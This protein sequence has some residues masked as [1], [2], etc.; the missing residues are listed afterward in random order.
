MKKLNSGNVAEEQYATTANKHLIDVTPNTRLLESLRDMG[1]DNYQAIADVID[2]SVDAVIAGSAK[3]PTV[4]ILTKFGGDGK[5]YITIVDNGIGMTEETLK[6]ALKLGS[7]TN[8]V[9]DGE[10]GYFGVGLN[11]AA[12]S[13]GRGFRVITKHADGEYLC[14]GF[15]LDSAITEK[16]WTFASI[17]KASTTDKK[18]FNELT[19]NSPTGTIIEIYK[20]DRISNRHKTHFDGVLLKNLGKIYRFYIS[21]KDGV[22]KVSFILNG[23]KIDAIDPM[24]RDLKGTVLLNKEVVNQKYQFNVDGQLAEIVVRYFYVDSSLETI[25]PT[26]KLGGRSN[27]FYI[28]RN[29]RQ[30]MAE[31]RLDFVGIDKQSSWLANFRAEILFDGKYDEIFKTNV[32]KSRIILPQSLTD[33][34]QKDVSEAVKFCK[35]EKKKTMPEESEIVD[36]DVQKDVK[37]II[38]QKNDT[39]TTPT[40]VTDKNGNPIKKEVIEGTEDEPESDD[41][42]KR[43]RKKEE[44]PRNEKTFNKMNVDFVNFGEDASFFSS[45]HQGNG[46]FLIRINLDH[47]FYKEFA[48]LDRQGKKFVIDLLHSFSLA[49]RQ[50]IYTDDLTQI[51]ELIRTWSNFLRRD[52]TTKE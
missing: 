25:Y 1:Y 38:K 30:I 26:E 21:G 27:G 39:K 10:L 4:K 37:S 16:S 44:K 19:N 6:E 18:Y 20:L 34:M 41:K 15:D 51:D 8:K 12:I 33:L 9:R 17:E 52:L 31:E 43:N 14:G 23:I 11:A 13:I 35:S 7:N 3:N 2:N 24:G 48:R 29:H 46:K 28:M 50:E 45:H 40:V 22:K 47:G 32:M 49:S 5:G 42:E 36:E